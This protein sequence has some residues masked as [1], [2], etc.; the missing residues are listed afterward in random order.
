MI[1][2]IVAIALCVDAY[3]CLSALTCGI[4]HQE[5]TEGEMRSTSRLSRLASLLL[6][7]RC[8]LLPS[9]RMRPLARRSSDN[10]KQLEQ[11]YIEKRLSTDLQNTVEDKTR[12]VAESA[13]G[14]GQHGFYRGLH[15]ALRASVEPAQY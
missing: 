1:G 13:K 4:P 7:A 3:V 15:R 11:R 14:L 9:R 2:G 5:P 10:G 12:P 8:R 6:C